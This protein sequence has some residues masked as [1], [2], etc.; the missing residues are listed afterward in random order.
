MEP[1]PCLGRRFIVRG[2]G[3]ITIREVAARA[4]VGAGTV[5]RVLNNSERVSD[6]TRSKVQA[7]IAD[8]GYRPNPLARGLS[9]G[10]CQ[11]IGVIVPDFTTASATERL[12]GVV[13]ALDGSLY[14]LVLF[15][16]ESPLHRDEHVASLDRHRADGL[17][18]MSLPLSDHQLERL[19]STGMPLVLIDSPGAEVTRVIVDDVAGGRLATDHLVGLGHR[20]I[21]FI[22]D[23]PDNFFGFTSSHD[24]ELG[25]RDALASAGVLRDDTLIRY[26]AHDREVAFDLGLELLTGDDPPTAVFCCSDVQALGVIEAG[27]HLRLDIPG[28]VSVVGFDDIEVARYLG[29]TTVRQPLFESGQAGT[30]LLLERLQHPGTPTPD[31]HTIELDLE[32]V[33]RSTTA[34]PKELPRG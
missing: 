16:V 33:V 15:N 10:R 14:D 26:G 31:A 28:D 29:I 24:R 9:R 4:G 20:R 5:S 13:A 32:M 3:V 27:R 30:E 23:R 1:I 22:G 7:A 11:T 18:V 19:N 6:A 17:V 34:A 2:D 12:K 21:G 8:L 25:Y